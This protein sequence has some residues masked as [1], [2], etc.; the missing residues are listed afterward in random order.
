M[1]T[2]GFINQIGTATGMYQKGSIRQSLYK[3]WLDT[4]VFPKDGCRKQL[5][6]SFINSLTALT[7]KYKSAKVRKAPVS[8]KMFLNTKHNLCH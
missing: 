4:E 1:S 6:N 2:M 8:F 5:V 7:A 3:I